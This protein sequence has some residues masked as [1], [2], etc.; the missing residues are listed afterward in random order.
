MRVGRLRGAR[1]RSRH[2]A[3]SR[4]CGRLRP[5]FGGARRLGHI[6]VDQESANGG[7]VLRGLRKRHG[8]ASHS[9]AAI[10]NGSAPRRG[11]IA[12]H[13]AK[14]LADSSSSPPKGMPNRHTTAAAGSLLRLTESSA[15]E[16]EPASNAAPAQ[17]PR[18]AGAPEPG[19]A[20]ET[21]PAKASKPIR[22]NLSAKRRATSVLSPCGRQVPAGTK[23]SLGQTRPDCTGQCEA[24]SPPWRPGNTGEALE[25]GWCP[26]GDSNSHS[27]AGNRF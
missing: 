4:R 1:K 14:A 2:A 3:R 6:S 7:P 12:N 26:R 19:A 22:A 23:L 16:D 5:C 11:G 17:A 20:Y 24:R 10:R 27:V 8:R 9:L 13:D 18:S 25:N 15:G 21:A